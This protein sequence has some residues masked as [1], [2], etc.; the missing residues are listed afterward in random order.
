MKANGMSP[1]FRTSGPRSNVGCNGRSLIIVNRLRAL[2]P[3]L[4]ALFYGAS[5]L[6]L[7]PDFIPILGLSDDLAVLVVGGVMVYRALR[8]LK[9][10]R[11]GVTKSSSIGSTQ[12]T[13]GR[14]VYQHKPNQGVGYELP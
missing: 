7:I 8:A 4:V 14:H 11:Q 10:H 12:V 13:S 3:L 6:D 9:S 1:K 5:P 2:F